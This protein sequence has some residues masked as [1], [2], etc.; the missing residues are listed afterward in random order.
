MTKISY[1]KSKLERNPEL[2]RVIEP[3]E[4]QCLERSH[5]EIAS[6]NAWHKSRKR[7]EMQQW[8]REQFDI[9]SF[10]PH[11]ETE[12]IDFKKNSTFKG[13]R[14]H[15]ALSPFS[16]N[17]M[18]FFFD[19]L[20]ERLQEMDY[21]KIQADKRKYTRPYWVETVHRQILRSNVSKRFKNISFEEIKIHI[22]FK[23]KGLCYL[24]LDA[25][26]S[27]SE[28]PHSSHDFGDLIYSLTN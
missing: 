21:M 5:E 20:A 11:I 10:K 9:F 25:I 4:E 26:I 27:E 1:F 12:A 28:L 13:F 18:L 23:N 22:L 3:D 6:Y 2:T 14:I 8:L 16:D 24:Q 19:F 15:S 17:Q 7:Y